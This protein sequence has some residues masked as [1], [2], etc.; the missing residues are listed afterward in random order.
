MLTAKTGL[1]KI[2]MTATAAAAVLL[3]RT[4]AG[5]AGGTLSRYILLRTAFKIGL[6]PACTL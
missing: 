4:V 5:T 3:G 1:L 6:V 2:L